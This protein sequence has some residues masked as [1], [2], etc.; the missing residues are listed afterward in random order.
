MCLMMDG[1]NGE[2]FGVDRRDWFF[3]CWISV[4]LREIVVGM[5]AEVCC[6]SL[7]YGEK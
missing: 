5:D 6:H 2:V 4:G 7:T 3:G 1:L